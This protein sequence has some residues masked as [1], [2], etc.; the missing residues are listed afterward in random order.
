MKKAY[1][2]EPELRSRLADFLV[3]H[4]D[5]LPVAKELLFK[6][7]WLRRPLKPKDATYL[8]S[9]DVRR[10]VEWRFRECKIWN[11]DRVHQPADYFEYVLM[12]GVGSGWWERRF[13]KQARTWTYRR[14][15]NKFRLFDDY[16]KAADELRAS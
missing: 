4:R 5:H 16:R 7:M 15:K 9:K 14:G 11:G 2:V 8:W 6:S 13:D 1:N 12:V 3:K 10:F